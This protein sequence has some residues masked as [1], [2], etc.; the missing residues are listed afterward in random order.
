MI[1]VRVPATSAN[2]GPGFDALGL[3]LTLYARVSFEETGSGLVIT[4]TPARYAGPDNLVYAAYEAA[5]MRMGIPVKGVSIHI[6][7]AIPV[8]RGL[9]SSAAMYAAGALAASAMHGNALSRA[10]LLEVTNALE[11]HPDNLAPALYGGFTAAMMHGGKPYVSRFEIS[12][13]LRFLA[14]VPEFETSTHEARAALPK[15]VAHADA[16]YTLSHALALTAA[17]RDGD[18]PA[19]GRAVSDRLHEPYRKT[20][21]PGFD[22]LERA[23]MQAGAAAFF[24]SG[25]GSTCMSIYTD[26]DF[27]LRAKKAASALPG[28]WR[29]LP[30]E[31]DN[32]GALVL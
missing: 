27:P 4:G 5:M 26:E 8:S 20:L 3:A 10:E 19:L 15:L 14:F 13:K 12:P 7:S 2:I 23:V 18:A 24:I 11:G 28:G 9:G 16:V 6:E 1:K 21:I 17:L 25:S 31:I 29:T 30:L 32:N 22:G